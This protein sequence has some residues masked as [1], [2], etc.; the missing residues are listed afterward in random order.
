[1]AGTDAGEEDGLL[2]PVRASAPAI[3][4]RTSHYERF[5]MS[6][7]GYNVC[8]GRAPDTPLRPPVCVGRPVWVCNTNFGVAFPKSLLL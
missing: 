3:V 5:T 1:M 6:G 4:T 7:A 2:S 8:A